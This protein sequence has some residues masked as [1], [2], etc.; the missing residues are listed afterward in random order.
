MRK[1]KEITI[2]RYAKPETHRIAWS[3]EPKASP[4]TGGVKPEEKDR[5]RQALEQ[6]IRSD[7]FDPSQCEIVWRMIDTGWGWVARVREA[8]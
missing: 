5:A 7:G 3:A 6:A 1:P 4:L 8:A 2:E